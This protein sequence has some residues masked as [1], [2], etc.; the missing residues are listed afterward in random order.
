MALEF[1]VATLPKLQLFLRQ[2]DP[3]CR[4]H[5]LPGL[6]SRLR[7]FPTRIIA[8]ANARLQV[9]GP[10]TRRGEAVTGEIDGLLV[11]RAG[12]RVAIDPALDD[13]GRAAPQPQI[14]TRKIVIADELLVQLSRQVALDDG[15]FQ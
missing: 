8:Q 10:F 3:Q 12:D 4:Q 5:R 6:E 14:E 11:P 13:T 1:A 9:A 7:P 2:V 15:L